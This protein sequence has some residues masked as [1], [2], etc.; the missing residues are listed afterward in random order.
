MRKGTI[1]HNSWGDLRV[2]WA[3][4]LFVLVIVVS[5][6]GVI[7]LIMF[8]NKSTCNQYAL[9]NPEL[10]FVWR[11]LGGCLVGHEGIYVPYDRLIGILS[12]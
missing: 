2:G 8:I 9:L 5:F 6:A 3:L 11:A 4:L 12:S 1:F 10:D 7:G